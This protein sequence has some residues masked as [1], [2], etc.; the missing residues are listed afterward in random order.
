MICEKLKQGAN[1]VDH[2]Y[3]L[4]DGPYSPVSEGVLVEWSKGGHA[5]VKWSATGISVWIL[6]EN[7]PEVVEDLG[8]TSRIRAAT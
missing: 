5:K 1:P 7:L 3:L 2:R 6:S 8:H 4:R